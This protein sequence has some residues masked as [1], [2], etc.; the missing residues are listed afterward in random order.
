MLRQS[1]DYK[2]HS[3]IDGLTFVRCGKKQAGRILDGRTW[4][5]E[6]EDVNVSKEVR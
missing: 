6:P 4:N 3:F 5:E 1:I 2:P